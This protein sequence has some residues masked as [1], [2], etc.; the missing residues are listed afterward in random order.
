MT[1]H[2]GSVLL[3]VLIGAAIACGTCAVLFQL[4]VAAQ[5]AVATQGSAADQQQRLR[6]AAEAVRRDLVMAGAGPSRGASSGP[7]I[8][9]LPPVL[10]SRIG[11]TNPDPELTARGDR[12]SIVYVPEAREQAILRSAMATPASPLAIDGAPVCAAATGCGFAAGERAI[13]YDPSGGGAP[14]ELLTIGAVDPAR[15]LLMPAAPLSYAYAA[16]ARVAL[17]RV[18]VYHL[19]TPTRRL[20]V[21]DGDRTEMPLVDR[22]VNMRVTYLADPRPDVVPSIPLADLGGT[23]PKPLSLTQLGDGPVAGLAPHRYDAD[24]LRVRRIRITL[25]VQDESGAAIR[26]LTASIDVAP[27][28]MGPR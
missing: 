4:A 6:V 26:D 18:R 27:P 15:D 11:L 13:V 1:N 5:A 17:V 3:E 9:V 20:M 28:N 10:P 16:G 24:L 25:T 8:R 23:A 14:Y 19:D 12:I 7:L 2:R 21:Y 22:V